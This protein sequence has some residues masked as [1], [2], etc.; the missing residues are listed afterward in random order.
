MWKVGQFASNL[1]CARRIFYFLCI[2]IYCVFPIF[3]C[4]SWMCS[5]NAILSIQDCYL[6]KNILLSVRRK[7]V[8]ISELSNTIDCSFNLIRASF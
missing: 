1:R 4:F 2:Y 7:D 6:V 8:A 5:V 3:Y